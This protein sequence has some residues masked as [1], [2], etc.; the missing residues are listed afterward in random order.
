VLA[1]DQIG[2]GTRL[3]EAR[4]F[5]ERYPGWSLMGRM[6]ADTRDAVDALVRLEEIDATRIFLM[7]Y[8]LGAKVGLF[9][10][11][12]DERVRAV[13][14]VC[15]VEALRL[16]RPEKGTEGLRHYSHLH[17][18]IPRFGFFLGHEARLPFDYD[19]VLALAAP[20]PVLVVAPTRDRYAPVDD[21]KRAIEA[22][23][24]VYR[25]AGRAEA[26]ELDTPVDINRFSRRTQ[27]RVYQWLDR[28]R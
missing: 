23:R 4:P 10:A 27:E 17:G 24:G 22:A 8:S 1:F 2:I 20:R 12:T 9:A 15:G 14:A 21:V 25:L 18:L 16:D 11:A 7:G 5:Y 6:V 3:H 26:L 13:A 19:E 28:Q